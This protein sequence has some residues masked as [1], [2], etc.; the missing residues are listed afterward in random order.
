MS[1]PK[2]LLAM[3]FADKER[4]IDLAQTLSPNDCGLKVGKEMFTRFGAE[5]V[6]AFTKRG[7]FVFLDLKFHDIPN[8][9]AQAVKASADLGVGMVNVHASGGEKMMIAAREALAHTQNKP[10]LIAVTVLTSMQRAD[11]QAVGIDRTPLEQ[12]MLLSRLAYRCGLDGVVCSA[13]E[14]PAIK[15]KNSA[16]FLTITPGIRPQGADVGD[17]QR[18]V[19][20]KMA[21]ALGS[22]FLVIGRPITQA[23][24]PNSALQAILTEMREG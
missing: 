16:D 21:V 24:D 15:A 12:A 14:V 9:V 17:Q 19:T 7:F 6:H 20:P 5:I 18:V 3:D 11:L 2:I 23:A 10:L 22:D 1:K 8:T 4:A 13:Q